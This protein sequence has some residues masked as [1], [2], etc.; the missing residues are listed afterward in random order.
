MEKKKEKEKTGIVLL[1]TRKR[2]AWC[3]GTRIEFIPES[4]QQGEWFWKWRNKDG[5]LDQ[6]VKDNFKQ[7]S[8]ISRFKCKKCLAVTGFAHL[9]DKA[10]GPEVKVSRRILV[11]KGKGE[12]KGTD[13]ENSE[14][15]S[16]DTKRENRKGDS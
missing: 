14:S 1:I 16:I 11:T 2:C 13:W 10:P 3:R 15:Q 4:G 5:S 12:R 6:R 7:A 8:Y 9:V